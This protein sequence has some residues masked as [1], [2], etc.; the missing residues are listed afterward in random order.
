MS[1]ALFARLLVKQSGMVDRTC[2]I[3]PYAV[4]CGSV[5]AYALRSSQDS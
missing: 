5:V 1:F 4:V 2:E 3:L